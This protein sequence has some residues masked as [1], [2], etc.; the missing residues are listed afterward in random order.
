MPKISISETG[1]RV[2]VAEVKATSVSSSVPLLYDSGVL[3]DDADA[4]YDLWYPY[5][6]DMTQG[7][8]PQ[9]KVSSESKRATIKKDNVIIKSIEDF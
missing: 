5:D 8:I 3:Y 6:A 9:T 1:P 7:E 4:Y 2:K